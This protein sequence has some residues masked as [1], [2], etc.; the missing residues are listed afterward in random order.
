MGVV[1]A[2]FDPELGRRVALK[3]MKVGPTGSATAG[4]SQARLLREARAL[5]GLTHPNVVTVYDVGRFGNRVYIAME[6]VEG[7]TL[8]TWIQSGPHPW[9]RAVEVMV[10][11]GRGLVA[12]HHQGIVHRDF[13]P[14]N[15]LLGRD[16]R[17]RVAD[18]GLARSG[19][20]DGSGEG[21]NPD[22]WPGSGESYSSRLPA[23]T[24][25]GA[26]MGTPGYMA[27]EQ[28]AGEALDAR[29]DQFS[30]CVTFYEV[31]FGHRPHA[32]TDRREWLRNVRLGK[33][34]EPPRDR[35]VPAAIRRAIARGLHPDP[36]QRWPT[37]ELLLAQ[38]ERIRR[39]RLRWPWLVAALGVAGAGWSVSGTDAEDPCHR[40]ADEM[41]AIWN[42]N[43]SDRL[44]AAF[45]E[46]GVPHATA[47]W[48]HTRSRIE[49]HAAQWVDARLAACRA[50]D[51]DD[52]SRD[53]RV[54]CLARRR[55]ELAALVDVLAV[56]DPEIVRGAAMAAGRLQPVSTCEHVTHALAAPPPELADRVQ[57]A[58][59]R[60][61]SLEIYRDSRRFE[62][63]L[64]LGRAV[65]READELGYAPLRA[66]ALY[67]HGRTHSEL[68]E[69]SSA[70]EHMQ[71]AFYLALE[72]GHDEVAAEAASSLYFV[73]AYR[74]GD[75]EVA[76]K[77]VGHAEAATE[78]LGPAASGPAW[79]LAH[80]RGTVALREADYGRARELLTRALELARETYGGDTLHTAGV[81]GNL[82]VVLLNHGELDEARS[83]FELSLS[84]SERFV[85]TDHPQRATWLNNLGVIEQNL[86]NHEDSL[87]Y[88]REAYDLES[89]IFGEDH[90]AIAMSLN[91]IGGALAHLGR[92][93]EAKAWFE[94]SIAAYRA[95]E[96]FDP[97]D[98]SRPIGNLGRT[99]S[100]LGDHEAGIEHL[101]EAIRIV[102]EAVGPSH[103][104]LGSFCV[105]LGSAYLA[106]G[107]HDDALD[108]MQRALEIDRETF[109]P[110]HPYVASSLSSIA[111]VHLTQGHHDRAVELLE[112]ALA[113][114][115]RLDDPVLLA[116]TRF[117]L[118]RALWPDRHQR[119]RAARLLEEAERALAAQ[120]ATGAES[121]T[122]LREW[123]VSNR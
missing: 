121:L 60:L 48:E 102:E 117:A 47:A 84:I 55:A 74:L 3:V 113:I 79:R 52:R 25:A 54:A 116:A 59:E 64:E 104:E 103:P 80:D 11:A 118:A 2:A 26:V 87:R 40:L 122:A 49:E 14:A 97:L 66:E 92:D 23:L 114:R 73:H 106:L 51:M 111:E 90:P 20:E 57:A 28:A 50:Q 78:R 7:E 38:L 89:G 53:L 43:A 72:C 45:D 86:G 32:G 82:G 10:E 76:A 101:H 77:W 115:T 108:P 18:F 56:P 30:F 69:W 62:R 110:D 16:G 35:R 68:A 17:V 5:A 4:E 83:S 96:G 99:L 33:L 37:L 42:P 41:H 85:G 109:G 91:N 19:Y 65:V 44:A 31:L 88:F 81:I 27:P 98:L 107:R 112:Q 22:A 6:L 70:V 120:G 71:D 94:R 1:H 93:I 61:A 39:P 34:R 75:A 13:K 21:L 67:R 100:K 29:S 24:E 105:N 46:S 8:K 12:A 15:V 9:P 63:A 58:R 95:A 36:D 123:L 119:E